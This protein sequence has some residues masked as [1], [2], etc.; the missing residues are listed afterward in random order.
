MLCLP[1]VGPERTGCPMGGAKGVGGSGQ[2]EGGQQGLVEARL[3]S[4]PGGAGAGRRC[5]A[6][7]WGRWRWRRPSQPASRRAAQ[8]RR[9]GRRHR[10]PAAAPPSWVRQSVGEGP[11]S[12]WSDPRVSDRWPDGRDG[13]LQLRDDE[14]E[15]GSRQLLPSGRR[16][17]A[18]GGAPTRGMGDA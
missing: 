11:D 9:R 16:P 4:R 8:P 10:A 2:A 1:V 18:W 15:R 3:G 12:Q 13:E 5:N 7:S 14:A 6:S 17:Q